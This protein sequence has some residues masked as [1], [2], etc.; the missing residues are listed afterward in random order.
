MIARHVDIVTI[1]GPT[2][3]GAATSSGLAP[4]FACRAIASIARLLAETLGA[5]VL[6]ERRLRELELVDVHRELDERAVKLEALH[7]VT[8]AHDQ[9]ALRLGV[10]VEV[11][12]SDL[13]EVVRRQRAREAVLLLGA[14][15]LVGAAGLVRAVVGDLFDTKMTT[16][17]CQSIEERAET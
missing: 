8:D 10:G 12:P 9:I 16:F 6:D 7:G 3:H 4:F 13:V 17:F 11:R 1:I 15:Q 14:Q 2:A 5:A